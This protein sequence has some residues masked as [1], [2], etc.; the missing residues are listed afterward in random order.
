MRGR[1]PFIQADNQAVL[2]A[3]MKHG[4]ADADFPMGKPHHNHISDRHV[5]WVQVMSEGDTIIKFVR[6]KGAKKRL[7]AEAIKTI[8]VV[9]NNI[10][11]SKPEKRVDPR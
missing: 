11:H 10:Y 8:T 3:G 6:K 9:K 5:L 4:M 1:I 7:H 2:L